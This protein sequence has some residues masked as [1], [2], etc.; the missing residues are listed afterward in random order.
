M[1][2]SSWIDN[3]PSL[4]SPKAPRPARK[5]ETRHLRQMPVAPRQSVPAARPLPD[6]IPEMEVPA[7]QDVKTT[8]ARQ[9]A[10]ASSV[11]LLALLM[12]GR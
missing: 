6:A 11:A 10:L 8:A 9:E 5:Y 3:F 4:P 12:S 2:S 1:N 7:A